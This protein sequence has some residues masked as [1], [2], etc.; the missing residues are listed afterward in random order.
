MRIYILRHGQAEPRSSSDA[1]RAL[2]EAGKQEARSV[3]EQLRGRGEIIQRV[4]TSP[5]RRAR[6]TAT[7]VAD[8]LKLTDL[9]IEPTIT[10]DES[11]RQAVE[12]CRLHLGQNLLFVSHMPFVAR[13]LFDLVPGAATAGF[14]TGEL[15]IVEWNKDGR[16]RLIERLFPTTKA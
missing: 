5:Y 6:E 10:P 11:P 9:S 7:I 8:A 3:A 14:Q 15:M 1:E 4:F 12:L 2:T 13:F 16:G